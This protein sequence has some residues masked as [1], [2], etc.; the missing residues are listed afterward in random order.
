MSRGSLYP[1]FQPIVAL[2][3]G[4][5]VGYEALIRGPSG[6]AFA[7]PDKLF[8][9]GARAGRL[10]ELDWICRAASCRAALMAGLPNT[11]PLFLNAEPATFR[12]PPPAQLIDTFQTASEQLQVVVEITERALGSDP[13]G[14]LAAILRLREAGMR[15]ALDDV[16]VDNSS[17]AM[18]PLISPDVIKIDRGVVQGRVTPQSSAVVNAVLAEAER[19]GAAVLAEGIESPEHLAIARS[20][21]ATLGQGWLFGR[22]E[23]L[24]HEFVP[25]VLNLPRVPAPELPGGTPY[26]V[27][28]RHRPP[29]HTTKSMLRCLSRHL[30]NKCLD[31]AEP[32]VLLA[33]FQ[34]VRYFDDEARRR[35]RRLADGGVL[36][37]VYA[38]GMAPEPEGKVRGGPLSPG[39]PMEREWVVVVLGAHFAGGL[40]CCER[41]GEDD[42]D[43]ENRAFDFVLTYDRPLVVAAAQPLLQRLL[44]T[45]PETYW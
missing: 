37:A 40:F 34:H 32:A 39:D 30:E 12:T 15:I 13:A 29:R 18:M 7:T 45:E 19:T 38:T 43:E 23:P 25:A 8:K 17:L 10:A 22:P 3:S 42:V 28:A 4:G 36:T 41:I 20:M 44:P 26:E 31:L 6:S 9:E 24:P 2:D 1:V 21:G 35:Y 14:L 11:V 16:G 27:A 5:I 33:G